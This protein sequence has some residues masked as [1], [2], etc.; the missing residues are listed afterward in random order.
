MDG[1]TLILGKVNQKGED[2]QPTNANRKI[3]D[4]TCLTP[5]EW[6]EE[7]DK[8]TLGMHIQYN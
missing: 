6:W 1:G 2:W 7:M 4:K 8:K 5:V 3:D